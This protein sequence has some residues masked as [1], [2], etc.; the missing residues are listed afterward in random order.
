[1]KY[2]YLLLILIHSQLTLA[3][4]DEIIFD[5]VDLDKVWTK[6]HTKSEY[7]VKFLIQTLR[8][9]ET[10]KR[11]IADASLKAANYGETIYDILK[12]G[13]SSLTDT[14]LIRKFSQSAPDQVIYETKSKVYVNQEL[15]ILDAILDTAHELTH[16]THREAFNPYTYKM[17]ALDFISSTIEGNGGEVDAFLM[18]CR[19]LFELF[20]KYLAN[21]S[22]CRKIQ[23]PNSGYFSKQLTIREF[24]KVGS[25]ADEIKQ[26]LKKFGN[27]IEETSIQFDQV[28]FISSAYGSPYPLA[29]IKEYRMVM[30]RVCEND[31][32]RFA[33][34]QAGIARSPASTKEYSANK[35][36]DE[37]I[38]N[39]SDR[40]RYLD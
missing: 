32:K 34:M 5:S 39:H 6:I 26:E 40:C 18:E 3:S 20:P 8:R 33:Y 37:L 28:S 30:G 14:T 15:S 21:K 27:A 24:Y 11:L 9:S 19:V 22:N 31:K 16:F 23:D 1:M 25:F 7:N 4:D 38:K 17:S 12:P 2:L 10:G 29:A 36:Y 13:Q 35:K